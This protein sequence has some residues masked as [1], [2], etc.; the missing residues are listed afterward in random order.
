MVAGF[1]QVVA[2]GQKSGEALDCHKW[3]AACG[4]QV[5]RSNS[6]LNESRESAQSARMEQNKIGSGMISS[7]F[8]RLNLPGVCGLIISLHQEWICHRLPR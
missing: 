5:G 2:N 6:K 8:T 4:E 1:R 7:P 3:I